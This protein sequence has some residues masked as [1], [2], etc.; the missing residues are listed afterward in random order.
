[1]GRTW[2]HVVDAACAELGAH[3][4]RGCKPEVGDSKAKTSV[5]AEDVLGLQVAVINIQGV[6]IFNRIEQLK[7][8]LL[9]EGVI[10]E[11][12]PLVQNLSEKVA[13][14]TVVHDDESVLVVL[15]YPMKSDNVGVTRCKLVEG[16]LANV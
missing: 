8:N 4:L 14:G 5:K 16:D 13:V 7:E 2:A 6:A 3:T 11:I 10:A 15:D 1:M 12:A 9:D